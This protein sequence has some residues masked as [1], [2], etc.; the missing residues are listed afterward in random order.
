M[1]SKLFWLFVIYVVLLTVAPGVA[2]VVRGILIASVV[3]AINLIGPVAASL[4][5]QVSGQDV[6]NATAAILA[7]L[8]VLLIIYMQKPTPKRMK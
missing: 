2:A 1:I 3:T 8:G 7:M 5:N 6:T 4:I